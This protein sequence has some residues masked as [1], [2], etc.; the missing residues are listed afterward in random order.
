MCNLQNKNKGKTIITLI[1]IIFI[2]GS[3]V[4]WF[5]L[6]SEIENSFQKIYDEWFSDEYLNM[7]YSSTYSE[8]PYGDELKNTEKI[9]TQLELAWVDM[10]EQA[11]A[12]KNCPMSK[13]KIRWILYY[14]EPEFRKDLARTLKLENGNMDS[15]KFI[16]DK[17]SVMNYCVEYFQCEYMNS[18]WD[19]IK[20]K[21][22]ESQRNFQWNSEVPPK[23]IEEI[24]STVTAFTSQDP[25][26]N[27]KNFFQKYYREGRNNKENGQKVEESQLWNDK[28]WN[29]T[30][31]DSP[32]DIMSDLWI[33]AKLLFEESQDPVQPVFYHLPMFRANND[34]IQNHKNSPEN[35]ITNDWNNWVNWNQWWTPWFWWNRSGWWEWEETEE[36]WEWNI[37]QVP[38]F[39]KKED[40]APLFWKNNP[41]LFDEY[42]DLIE[43]LWAAS[44][45]TNNWIDGKICDDKDL[46]EFLDL[47]DGDSKWDWK[48]TTTEENSKTQRTNDNPS[49]W[50]DWDNQ[51]N[52]S[53]V[54]DEDFNDYMDYLRNLLDKYSED[55]VKKSQIDKTVDE[56][57]NCLK[58]CEWTWL[59]LD[60]K[61][62][63]K[64]MCVCGE[65]DSSIFDPKKTDGLLWP[66]LKIR[67]CTVPAQ[68]MNFSVWWK[69]IVSI[70]EWMNEIYGVVDKLSREWKL[71]IWTKQYNF[72]DS[73]TKKNKIADTF[74]FSIDLELVDIANRLP[75]YTREYKEFVAKKNNE[76]WQKQRWIKNPIDNPSTKNTYAGLASENYNYNISDVSDVVSPSISL[77][78]KSD[79]TPKSRTISDPSK[80][81]NASRY[82]SLLRNIDV[83]IFQQADFRINA[84]SYTQNFYN[85]AVNLYEKKDKK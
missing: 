76:K 52:A 58:G 80:D 41:S 3:S 74:A 31:E 13:K 23:S 4:Y 83:F 82:E 71:F 54:T 46:D 28:Y 18:Q 51:T 35:N 59:R 69:R 57:E 17:E 37:P 26:T 36:W 33:I 29:A 38:S 62:S 44:L 10:V 12:E 24:K 2:F 19:L 73:T 49:W 60:Q 56:I 67:F 53:D 78:K 34:A 66:L 5:D 40:V 79:M 8:D 42:D 70:E 50:K 32:Y 22:S 65:I 30:L 81:S 48:T 84:S 16:L 11:L 6:L 20:T 61:M 64:L 75:N 21:H 1:A 55:D 15:N 72:L 7:P 43:G 85:Y 77:N 14:Y 63:C 25:E 9:N 68:N 27:C 45:N 47:W 39:Q